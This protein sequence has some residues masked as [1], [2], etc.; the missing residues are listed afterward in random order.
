M[1]YRKEFGQTIPDAIEV[2]DPANGFVCDIGTGCVSPISGGFNV[3]EAYAELLIPILKDIPFANA[4]NLTVGDRYLEVQ[5]LRQHEQHEGR[6]RIS[7]DRRP[8]AARH[9]VEGVPRTDD[10]RSVTRAH[11]SDAPQAIDP[12]YGLV[13]TNAACV[14]RAG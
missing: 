9:G 6:D 3:K 14:G 12:C 2:P 8:A 11:A 4:L 7:S 5:Q 1:S 10:H 13:G